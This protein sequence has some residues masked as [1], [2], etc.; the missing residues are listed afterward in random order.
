MFKMYSKY[1]MKM[2]LHVL[3]KDFDKKN[4]F[5]RQL[6]SIQ[7]IAQFPISISNITQPMRVT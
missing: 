3:C 1:C 5:K 7:L 2:K 6:K 4:L